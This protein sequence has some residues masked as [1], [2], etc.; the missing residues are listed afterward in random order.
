MCVILVNFSFR[1]QNQITFSFPVDDPLDAVAV[2]MGGGLWGLVA[3]ALFQDEGIVYGGSAEV[4]AWNMIGALAIMGWAG[5]LCFLMFGA[6]RLVGWLR[7]PIE[8]EIQGKY[9]LIMQDD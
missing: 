6:L 4:L 5:G 9:F 3:V 7:I 1:T 8:M 2:H